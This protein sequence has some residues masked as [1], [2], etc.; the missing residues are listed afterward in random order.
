MLGILI[1]IRPEEKDFLCETM[2]ECPAIRKLEIAE[3]GQEALDRMAVQ[4]AEF[5]VVDAQN[6][7]GGGILP[8]SSLRTGAPGNTSRSGADL[9]GG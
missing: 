9:S 8:P 2:L 3:S 1:G 6:I 4:M 5:A 7:Q